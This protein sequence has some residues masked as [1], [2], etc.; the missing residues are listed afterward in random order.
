MPSKDFSHQLQL[1]E[2]KITG[3]KKTSKNFYQFDL[4]KTSPFDVCPNCATPSKTVYDHVWIKPRDTL[5]RDKKIVLH[6]KKRRFYCKSCKRPFTEPVQ[7][8]KKGFRTTDRFR[9]HIMWCSENFSN[10]YA[11]ERQLDVSSWLVH[12]A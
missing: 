5:I 10:L 6:I 2:L 3:H 12:K 11:V 1:P 9:R 7:G 8:I 4:L